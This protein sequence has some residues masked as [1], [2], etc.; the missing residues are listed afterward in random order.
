MSASSWYMRRLSILK[1]RDA[2]Y[3][4][5]TIQYSRVNGTIFRAV[6]RLTEYQIRNIIKESYD[7]RKE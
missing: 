5:K 7:R 3:L 1:S 2:L 6:F 4:K